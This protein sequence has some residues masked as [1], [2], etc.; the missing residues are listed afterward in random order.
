MWDMEHGRPLA[1]LKFS[2]GKISPHYHPAMEDMTEEEIDMHT[3]SA[4]IKGVAEAGRDKL[5]VSTENHETVV[6]DLNSFEMERVIPDNV[7]AVHPDGHTA[8]SSSAFPCLVAFDLFDDRVERVRL[9]KAIGEDGRGKLVFLPDG[10]MVTTNGNAI[11]VWREGTWECLLTI[12]DAHD[13]PEK[14]EPWERGI[15]AVVVLADGNRVATAS[16]VDPRPRVWDLE[17]GESVVMKA[18]RGD[19]PG[20]EHLA[21]HPSGLVGGTPAGLCL[22]DTAT[23]DVLTALEC[24]CRGLDVAPDGRIACAAGKDL[25]VLA[26]EG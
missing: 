8:F 4:R 22:W 23:G 18:E 24:P 3:P 16:A 13:L 6:F 26:P 20:V 1:T 10:R 7:M 14:P 19:G 12:E 11:R 21:A 9:E 2:P 15:G 5:L 17:S 25:V